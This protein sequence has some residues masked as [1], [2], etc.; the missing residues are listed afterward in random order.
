[1]KQILQIKD[2]HITLMMLFFYLVP[3][4]IKCMNND[5]PRRTIIDIVNC[6]EKIEKQLQ[7]VNILKN[8]LKVATETAAGDALNK[9]MKR[10]DV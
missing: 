7:Y 9:I 5:V 2:S 8:Y 4:P 3:I 10:A 1:M 6:Q